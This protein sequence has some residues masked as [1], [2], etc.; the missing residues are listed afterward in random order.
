MLHLC[1]VFTKGGA[2]LWNAQNEVIR[3]ASPIS[4]FI[5][6]IL[7]Q[8]KAGAL[9][10]FDCGEYTLKW[11]FHND[12][13]L[14][15]VALYVSVSSMFDVDMFLSDLKDEF[16]AQFRSVLKVVGTSTL[17][18][19]SANFRG[20][21]KRFK[22]L[23]NKYIEM[24]RNGGR[25]D[26][27][28]KVPRTYQEKKAGEKIGKGG[29]KGGDAEA[30]EEK[31]EKGDS[32][33]DADAEGESGNASEDVSG[34]EPTSAPRVVDKKIIE[35]KLKSKGRGAGSKKGKFTEPVKKPQEEFVSRAKGKSSRRWDGL[36]T[37]VNPDELD[38]SKTN[39]LDADA[40]SS[41]VV[42]ERRD[43]EDDS[44]SPIEDVND[45]IKLDAPK[46]SSGVFG[47][48]SGL[49]GGR[50]LSKEDLEK[51]LDSIRQ[52]LLAKN[53]ATNIADQIV[54]GVSESLVGKTIPA[55]ST[56]RSVVRTAMEET[57]TRILTPKR[58]VDVV[59]EVQLAK[60]QGRPYSIVFVGVNGVGKSTSLAKICYYLKARG[61]TVSIAACD[62]FRSGAVEQLKTHARR[63]DV[64]VFDQGYNKDASAVA[65]EGIKQAARRGDDVILID[66]AGRMQD[67][68][69]L[70]RALSKLIAV[71]NPDLV[72][73]VGEALVG[74]D[75]VDQLVKFNRA[76]TDLSTSTEPRVIDGI[77][78]TKFDTVDDKVGSAISMTYTTGQPIVFVGVGQD[79]GDIRRLSVKT[80]VN[81]LLK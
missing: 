60:A 56:F 62:T 10:S 35:A 24:V 32:D 44:D 68:E 3:G 15:F 6:Q 9:K 33:H 29:K 52:N 66:T 70:M 61:L 5:E 47:F 41:T 57:L 18:A 64:E 22:S 20:F 27:Q 77:V 23:E 7:L 19:L 46:K 79:Y 49:I 59:R 26:S 11:T 48:F 25:R 36:P 16:V 43:S 55:F 76:L 40:D 54:S 58:N 38:R 28:T 1:T 21:D 51:P 50:A 72:L 74:N 37:D 65:A 2:V 69:P 73:F 34:E 13:N 53:V 71:N 30:K 67:N 42:I 63:L 80:L 4:A 75:A 78:L 45:E 14:I 81:K 39:L 17:P 8:D 31:K 12:L